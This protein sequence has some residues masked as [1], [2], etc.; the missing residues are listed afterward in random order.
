MGEFWELLIKGIP[1]GMSNTLPGISGGTMALVL[2]IYDRLITGIKKIRFKILIPIF[3]GAVIGVLGSSKL[4][5]ILLVEQSNLMMAFLSGLILFSVKVT[6]VEVEKFD[7]KAILL[8]IVGLTI[9]YFY[10]VEINSSGVTSDIS[11]FKFFLGGVIG[12]VAMILPGISGGTILIM[13]GLYQRVIQGI[14]SFNLPLIIIFGLGVGSGL[15]SFSWLLSYLLNNYRSLLMSFLTGL[16]LGSMRSVLPS[17]FGLVEIIAFIMGSLII[18][19]LSRL[20][21]S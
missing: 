6:I 21:Q 19:G 4:I 2:K 7:I 20:N 12:S 8:F 3:L 15:L 13:L 9:A 17:Q 14:S 1:I 18:W 5:T 16:I 11:L 10:S